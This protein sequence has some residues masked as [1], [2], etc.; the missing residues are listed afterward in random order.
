[1][2]AYSYAVV[3]RRR[4]EDF[5]NGYEGLDIP[6]GAT[7]MDSNIESRR[8]KVREIVRRNGGSWITG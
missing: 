1:M 3:V 2:S 7:Y 4:L 8:R 5:G 6:S